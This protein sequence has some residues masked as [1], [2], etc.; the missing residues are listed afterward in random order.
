MIATSIEQSKKL[1]ALGVDPSTADMYWDFDEMQK[2]HCLN[3]FEEGF[4][5]HSYLLGEN[6]PAWSVEVLMDMLPDKIVGYRGYEVFN[7]RIEKDEQEYV[8]HYSG[9][10]L[11]T[12]YCKNLIDAVFEMVCKLLKYKLI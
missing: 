5:K 1:V 2:F 6:L 11:E 10:F 4:N 8:V 9:N 12:S 7:L 3:I